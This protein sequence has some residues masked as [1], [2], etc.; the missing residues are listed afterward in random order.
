MAKV[1]LG[2]TR[3]SPCNA[4]GGGGSPSRGTPVG[5]SI[6]ASTGN[7]I[8]P[9]L[10]A[11]APPIHRSMKAR[12][13]RL[14]EGVLLHQHGLSHHRNILDSTHQETKTE[15]SSMSD[16]VQASAFRVEQEQQ[17]ADAERDAAHKWA[18]RTCPSSPTR[19][20]TVKCRA[21]SSVEPARLKSSWQESHFL[22]DFRSESSTRSDNRSWDH[23]FLHQPRWTLHGPKWMP[24]NR[25]PHTEPVTPITDMQ[26]ASERHATLFGSSQSHCTEQSGSFPRTHCTS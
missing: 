19:Q 3:I 9:R 1:S 21:A 11:H 15:L 24:K 5:Q 23:F 6:A 12:C 2:S 8:V 25:I 17:R 22:H 26:R 20:T 10:P 7:L 14:D 13:R 16:M 18:E 4:N